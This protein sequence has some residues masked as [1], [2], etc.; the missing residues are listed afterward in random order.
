MPT[1]TGPTPRSPR[2]ST[3]K[4]T[5]A[6]KAAK[7]APSRLADA[8]APVTVIDPEHRR[9]LI[10]Q[11]AY[12]RAEGRNFAPG[13]EAQDWLSAEVEVDTMLTSGIAPTDN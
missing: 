5:A 2:R 13:F 4:T 12:F 1:P 3:T 8:I 11:A 9:A 7:P 6:P 10:A